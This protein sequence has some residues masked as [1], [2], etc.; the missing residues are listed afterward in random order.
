[1]VYILYI[2]SAE[3]LWIYANFTEKNNFYYTSTQN[4]DIT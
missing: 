3:L 4:N 2:R 1:M